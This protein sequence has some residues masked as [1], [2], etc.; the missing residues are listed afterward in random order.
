M[1]LLNEIQESLMQQD[2]NI[3]PILLKLRFLASRLGSEALEEW[4]KFESEGYP[5]Q[6]EVPGY[7][8]I[9]VSYTAGFNGPFGASISNAPI[10]GYLIAQLAGDEWNLYELRQSI[11]GI[12]SLINEGGVKGVLHINSSNLILLLQGNVYEG[13]ACNSV[14]GSLSKA[15]LVEVQNA[16]RSRVLE[17]TI[18]LENAIPGA[19][20]IQIGKKM[21]DP[22]S[23]E[24]ETA[25]HITNQVI[26]GNFT[27]ISNSG[28]HS[29]F[30]LNINQGDA[31]AVFK[32]LSESGF[33]ADDASEFSTIV[34]SE[35][36]NAAGPFGPKAAKWITQNVGKA[37]DGTWKMGLAVA[38]QVLTDAAMKYYGLK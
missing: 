3:G 1:G 32:A 27:S 21:N 5:S 30:T 34:A 29:N 24:S 14:T 26:H 15:S 20:D 16:V 8:K 36:P 35:Q 2:R 25:T 19:A 23:K 17:L 38:T 4:V 7:R 6:A 28:A 11:S 10:P 22:E 37:V 13:Y 31:G 18:A 33:P 12:D 9:G